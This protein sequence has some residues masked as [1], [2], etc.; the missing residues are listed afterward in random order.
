MT[1][2][3][4]NHVWFFL[5]DRCNLRCGYCFFKHKT[6]RSVVTERTIRAAMAV[7]AAFSRPE[8]ILSG[9]EPL[10]A[11]PQ[12]RCLIQTIRRAFPASYI[13]MQSNAA[14][15]DQR[16]IV[17]L[18]GHRVNVEVGIDGDEATTRANRPGAGEGYYKDIC[19]AMEQLRAAGGRA[20]VTMTVYPQ[21]AWQLL[22]NGRYLALMGA[23][24][25]EV[26]P[27]FLQLWDRPAA[28]AFLR[29]YRHASA[30]A[31][32]SRN[33][34]LI[35]RGYSEVC[36]GAWDMVILP[37]GKVLPNWTF[38]SFPER[39]RKYF[40]IMD[41]ASGKARMLP[42]AR[43]YFDALKAFISFAGGKVVTYRQI[44]NFNA[45]LALE[46]S[47]ASSA[48]GF[49]AYTQ[50]CQDIEKIDQDVMARVPW[51]RPLGGCMTGRD[52]MKKV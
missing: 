34:K 20:T 44:S 6:G 38:L 26:H 47:A 2:L 25:V 8:F 33:I 35:G 23:R 42:G 49:A 29:G 1:T 46:K 11:W 45:G 19:R 37:D 21:G 18:Q 3:S 17:Y 30:Y 12:A 52:I 5:T 10:L 9:G 50:L 7:A 15:L 31:L 39:V 40:Y 43:G 13:S 41:L 32:K 28:K 4:L 48:K 24:H 51:R 27:A 16:K 14:L 22:A 36:P